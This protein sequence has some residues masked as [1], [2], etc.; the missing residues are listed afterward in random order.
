MDVKKEIEL[1]RDCIKNIKEGIRAHTR[2]LEAMIL[3]RAYHEG[4]IKQL[5]KG[6]RHDQT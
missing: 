4:Q 3:S 6:E 5:E 1:H 2:L